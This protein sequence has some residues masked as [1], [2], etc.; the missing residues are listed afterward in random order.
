MH[1]TVRLNRPNTHRNAQEGKRTKHQ[2][3]EE[4]GRVAARQNVP[5]IA[6]RLRLNTG[7]PLVEF[8]R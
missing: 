7:F 5:K 4:N 3:R 1:G 2:D 8:S 6:Y